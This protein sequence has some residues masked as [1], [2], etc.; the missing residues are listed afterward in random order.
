M[1]SVP[2]YTVLLYN[3]HG[4]DNRNVGVVSG[5]RSSGDNSDGVIAVTGAEFKRS[6]HEITT[7]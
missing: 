3:P 1:M 2:Q 7:I 5:A 4:V 6:F